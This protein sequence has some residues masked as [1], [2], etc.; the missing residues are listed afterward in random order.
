MLSKKH[1][2]L[3]A[4]LTAAAPAM[5]GDDFGIWT[6]L[7]AEK[8]LSKKTSLDFGIDFR[9]AQNLEAISRWG[10]SVGFGYKPFKWLKFGAGYTYIYDR[11]PQEAVVNYTSKGR[12][13]GY[14][15]NHGYWRSKYRFNFDVTG[16]LRLGGFSVSLR[17]RYLLTEYAAA[18]YVRDRYRD[19]KQGGYTGPTYVWDGQEFMGY[20]QVEQEKSSHNRHLLR[21]RLQLEYN[22]TNC[23]VTPYV[24]YEISNDLSKSLELKKTRLSAGVEWKINKKNIVSLGYIYQDGIDDDSNSDM[25][26]LD[27]GYKFRF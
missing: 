25:H 11:T 5:A 7:S 20:E 14:N 26:V 16:K 21:S 6:E 24:S 23:P 10:A 18:D 4:A 15:V 17:E 12:I 19:P 3:A 27:I 1:L 8:A 2:L 13:N 22:F 9:S